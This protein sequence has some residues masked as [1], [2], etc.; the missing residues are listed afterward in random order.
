V[1][2]VADTVTIEAEGTETIVVDGVDMI[3]EALDTEVGGE[4]ADRRLLSSG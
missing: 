3:T 4:G 1:V 2:V